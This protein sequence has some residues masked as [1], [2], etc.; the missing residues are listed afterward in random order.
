LI[1]FA[2]VSASPLSAIR[3]G[4]SR[5][6]DREVKGVSL[7]RSGFRRK[8]EECEKVA[9]SQEGIIFRIARK[10]IINSSVLAWTYKLVN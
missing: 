3:T 7:H 9:A 8:S 2:T 1:Q 6:E 5:V 4:N 10:T